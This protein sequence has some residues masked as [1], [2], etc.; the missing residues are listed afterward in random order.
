MM[1]IINK[2]TR[3]FLLSFRAVYTILAIGVACTITLIVAILRPFDARNS[4]ITTTVGSFLTKKFLNFKTEIENHDYLEKYRPCIVLP[5]HQEN[6]DLLVIGPQLPPKTLS[7]GKRSLLFIP[8]FGITFWLCG[9]Y[10]INRKNKK[11]A[12]KTMNKI[13]NDLIH[14]KVNIMI[15]PEGTRSRGRPI[16]PFKT[17]AFHLAMETNMSILPMVVSSYNPFLD[18]GRWKTGKVKIKILEPILACEFSKENMHS[19]ID[20]IRLSMMEVKSQLDESLSK[21]LN[22]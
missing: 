20:Q 17:G 12:L 5:N 1:N 6:L 21:E 19:K 15:L 11:S 18:F 22:A 9:H 3:F 7:L 4:Y 14:K 2:L 8:F 10:L 13:K 16:G